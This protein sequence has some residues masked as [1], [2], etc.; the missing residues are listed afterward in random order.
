MGRSGLSGGRTGRRGLLRGLGA[1]G[2]GRDGVEAGTQRPSC[3]LGPSP[4]SQA[5]GSLRQRR[6]AFVMETVWGAGV[7]HPGGFP[8]EVRTRSGVHVRR[9]EVVRANGGWRPVPSP[10]TR[11]VPWA[12]GVEAIATARGAPWPRRTLRRSQLT[13]LLSSRPSLCPRCRAGVAG[14]LTAARLCGPARRA[15]V[16]PSA[17]PAQSVCG[18]HVAGPGRRL[19][20]LLACSAASRVGDRSPLGRRAA[21]LAVPRPPSD[22]QEGPRDTSHSS[23]SLGR[24]IHPRGSWCSL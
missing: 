21:L 22:P 7:Q 13:S 20:E 16:R 1:A 12:D 19:R 9:A 17:V 14:G 5:C 2:S 4:G 18:R 11:P 24:F 10:S 3:P 8:S 15:S 23:S 6:E